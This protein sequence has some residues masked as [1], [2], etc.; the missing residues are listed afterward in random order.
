MTEMQRKAIR[1]A[2]ADYKKPFDPE[3]NFVLDAL[4][5]RYDVEVCDKPDF[6]IDK[7]L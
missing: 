5:K 1:I 3:H 2:F 4:R 7:Q 6:V